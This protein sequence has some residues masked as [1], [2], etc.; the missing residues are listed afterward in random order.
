VFFFFFFFNYERHTILFVNDAAFHAFLHP[1][2][3]QFQE[4]KCND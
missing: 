1:L 4:V 3:E 2:N